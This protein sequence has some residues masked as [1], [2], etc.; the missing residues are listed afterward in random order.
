[1]KKSIIA[2]CLSLASLSSYSTD[3][4]NFGNWAKAEPKVILGGASLH[5]KAVS[6][7]NLNQVNPSLGLELWDVQVVYVDKNSWDTS[8]W[9]VTYTPDYV[10]NDYLE[11][12]LQMGIA[13]GYDCERSKIINNGS[14]TLKADYCTSM[15]I[16]PLIGATVTVKPFGNGLGVFTSVTP[17][18]LMFGVSQDF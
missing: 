11:L 7:E 8:S 9:Y 14:H 5:Y 13:S 2:L 18:A 4:S 3:I 17:S 16:V 12:S 15:G 6:R 1:M 10:V